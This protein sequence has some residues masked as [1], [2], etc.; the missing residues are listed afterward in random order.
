MDRG[1]KTHQIVNRGI[2]VTV[3]LWRARVAA[4]CAIAPLLLQF[5]FFVSAEQSFRFMLIVLRGVLKD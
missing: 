4:C 1:A 2:T 5:Q 3:A